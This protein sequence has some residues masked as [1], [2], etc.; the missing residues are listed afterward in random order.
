MAQ[1]AII[2]EHPLSRQELQTA[3]AY[4]M[5]KVYI[6][7]VTC[8]VSQTR[9]TSGTTLKGRSKIFSSLFGKVRLDEAE[10]QADLLSPHYLF[11]GSGPTKRFVD[12]F[13]DFPLCHLLLGS[14]CLKH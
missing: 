11:L 10:V 12:R 13:E 3:L 14:S 5:L 8:E 9:P 7:S 4:P 6:P 2:D 1:R